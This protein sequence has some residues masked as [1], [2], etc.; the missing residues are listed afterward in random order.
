VFADVSATDTSTD[1][2]YIA[3]FNLEGVSQ[4]LN[5]TKIS[6]IEIT[7]ISSPLSVFIKQ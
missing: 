3:T 5:F 4:I 1:E 2:T 6:D 7:E